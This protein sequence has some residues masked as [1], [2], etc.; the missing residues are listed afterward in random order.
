[1]F[2]LKDKL[3]QSGLSSIPMQDLRFRH[4]F[5]QDP[6]LSASLF[7]L[8]VELEEDG[9]KLRFESLLLAIFTRLAERH[10]EVLSPSIQPKADR[11]RIDIARQYMEANYHRNL[12]L[13]ELAG[14]SSL[15][16]SHFLRIFRDT[17][18]LTPHAYLTQRRIEI[19]TTLLRYGTPLVEIANL[20]GFTDQSHFTKK[21]KRMLGVTPGQYTLTSSSPHWRATLKSHRNRPPELD[22]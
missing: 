5:V 18:G 16:A 3:F 9:D 20:V 11:S 19:A 2:Y 17:V 7:Q 8:H 10:A 13:K 14:L 4:A 22:I 15:S 12:S 21:F 1:M 6:E